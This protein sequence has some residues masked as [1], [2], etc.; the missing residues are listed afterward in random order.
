MSMFRFCFV[1]G[2]FRFQNLQHAT[3]VQ[4]VGI[5]LYVCKRCTMRIAAH[6]SKEDCVMSHMFCVVRCSEASI[7]SCLAPKWMLLLWWFFFASYSRSVVD[8]GPR[9]M[10]THL[11]A[12]TVV[13]WLFFALFFANRSSRTETA[14]GDGRRK[15][16]AHI[17][18]T[19]S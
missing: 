19:L 1:G 7:S 9:S 6:V 5:E 15:K 2:F 11:V 17:P 4:L 18:K 16:S 14:A 8:Y 10:S 12:C 3:S 13:A